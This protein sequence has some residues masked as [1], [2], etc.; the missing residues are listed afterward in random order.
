MTKCCNFFYS[1]VV[2]DLVYVCIKLLIENML[3][4]RRFFY[5]DCFFSA[6]FAAQ[7][8]FSLFISNSDSILSIAIY[9]YTKMFAQNSEIRSYVCARFFP[10]Y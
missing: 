5:V 2:V 1:V 7:L 8:F 3:A 4:K 10:L 6:S 9:R